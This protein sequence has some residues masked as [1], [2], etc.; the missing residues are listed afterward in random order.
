MPKFQTTV[1]FS[2][3]ETDTDFIRV[4]CTVAPTG[5]ELDNRINNNR[6][7]RNRIVAFEG[8]VATPWN[9]TFDKGGKYTFVAQE[10][11]KGS[12]YGGGYEGDP[13]TANKETKVGNETTLTVYVGQRVTQQIGPP[14]D[15]ATLVLWVWNEHIRETT[16]AFHGEDSPAITAQAPSPGLKTAIEST[17]VATALAALVGADLSASTTAGNISTWAQQ[18][19]TALNVHFASTVVHDAADT[20]NV[21]F[22][23]FYAP[24]D[25]KSYID[26]VNQGLKALR[27][28]V[29]NDTGTATDPPI[30]DA[31][32]GPDSG[33]FHIESS[34]LISDRAA[35][36]LYQSVGTFAEAYG[37]LADLWRCFDYHQRNTAP[38][39]STLA[40][41]TLT[42]LPLIQQVH[43]AV[44]EVLADVTP[45]TPSAQSNGVQTLL[46][47]A[48][49][50]E[51]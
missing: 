19:H 47:V 21:L 40:I 9:Y 10:Y 41:F 32:S 49:F 5:S 29:T 27:Q 15:Q 34:E 28:H 8:S 48:G 46:S 23:T 14:G 35:V 50:K 39:G 3:T 6:D 44:L 7:P 37:G 2:L 1:T 45:T 18:L 24:V 4:W 22:N 25:Q 17:S 33:D 38:H 16:K 11:I 12:G 31:I 30:G 20:Y 43:K 26:F 13:N 42:T 51:S 36:P